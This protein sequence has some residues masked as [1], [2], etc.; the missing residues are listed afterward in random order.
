MKICKSWSNCWGQIP[1]KEPLTCTGGKSK[2]SALNQKEQNSF[3]QWTSRL[4]VHKLTAVGASGRNTLGVVYMFV[5]T[6][7]HA[8]TH[9]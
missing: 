6:H 2:V 4:V 3:E 8:C 7:M 5:Y 1:P 9:T